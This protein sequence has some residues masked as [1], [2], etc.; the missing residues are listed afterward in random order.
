MHRLIPSLVALLLLFYSGVSPGVSPAMAQTTEGE[1]RAIPPPP[2]V[3]NPDGSGPPHQGEFDP[4]DPERAFDPKTGQNMHWDCVKKTWVDSKTGKPIPGGFNGR[5]ASDGEAIPPPPPVLNPDGSGPPH[6]GE[7]D[8][9]DPERAFDPTTGQNMYWDRKDKNW[10]DSKTGKAVPGG[11][12]GRR[13]TK[14]CPEKT[15]TGVP[16]SGEDSKATKPVR[17]AS[18][19]IKKVAIV[20]VVGCL[21]ATA[22]A[23]PVAVCCAQ[24]HHHSTPEVPIAS[25]PMPSIPPPHMPADLP[26]PSLP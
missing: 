26:M 7:F 15:V 21:L 13:T 18:S 17:T 22:I 5:R 4:T 14:K 10:K 11:F 9:T 8:P 2:P 20:V 25:S 6:Q 12:N 1:T 23:V 3:L 24:H 19:T 16:P